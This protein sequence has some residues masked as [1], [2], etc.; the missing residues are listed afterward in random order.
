MIDVHKQGTAVVVSAAALVLA[1][2]FGAYSF[3]V[4][5]DAD[6]KNVSATETV[7]MA[8]QSIG[9]VSVIHNGKT[10]PLNGGMPVHAG[11]TVVVGRDATVY[12]TTDYGARFI[13]GP[14]SE[15]RF[16]YYAAHDAADN[17]SIVLTRGSVKA[18]AVS[19]GGA[20]ELEVASPTLIS[21]VQERLGGAM[22]VVYDDTARRTTLYVLD[23][24]ALV[25]G[26]ALERQAVAGL[27][28]EKG[29]M[30]SVGSDGDARGVAPIT[31]D[32]LVPL[33]DSE[34]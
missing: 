34:F 16:E 9:E 4:L 33:S 6:T 29:Y 25:R 31:A 22:V 28:L 26:P 27:S 2:L 12:F 13:L 21:T 7:A 17:V 30:V 32:T 14:D 19:S 3:F 5:N 1:A 8:V 18:E 15:V 11:D 24:K 10:T 23:N 20:Q